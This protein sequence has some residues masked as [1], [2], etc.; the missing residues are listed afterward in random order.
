MKYELCPLCIPSPTI[1]KEAESIPIVKIGI[2]RWL[3]DDGFKGEGFC[4]NCDVAVRRCDE[5]NNI[6]EH[7]LLFPIWVGNR[8]EHVCSKCMNQLMRN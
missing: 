6:Y 2:I 8:D 4:S 5:C 1:T 3:E 7:S